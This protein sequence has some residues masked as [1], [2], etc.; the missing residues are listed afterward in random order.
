MLSVDK[1]SFRSL[2]PFKYPIIR[3]SLRAASPVSD[4]SLKEQGEDIKIPIIYEDNRATIVL[5]ENGR[6]SAQRTRHLNA[7]YTVTPRV[8]RVIH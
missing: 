2:V 4:L 6:K 3:S 1:I 5:T 8:E 7:K